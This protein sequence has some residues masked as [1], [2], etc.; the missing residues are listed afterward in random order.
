[1]GN[2][3]KKGRVNPNKAGMYFSLAVCIIALAIGSFSAVSRKSELY[4]SQATTT[5]SVVE[6]R[7]NQ[8]DVKK[9]SAS[10]ATTA[11][12]TEKETTPTTEQKTS[13]KSTETLTSIV[14]NH[15]VLPVGGTLKKEFSNEK[16]QYSETYGDWRIHE[17][18]DIAAKKGTEVCSSGKGKVTKVYDDELLGKTV[19]INHGNEIDCYYCGLKS[20]SVSKGDVVEIGE[21]IGVIGDIP[22]EIAD[23]THLHFMVLKDGKEVDPIKEL[24]IEDKQ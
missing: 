7:K 23:E 17:G 5:E 22:S 10:E 4:E 19:V 2:E 16:L 12:N 13:E 3:H 1:M 11:K 14:A 18:I 20:V 6:I 24:E 8:T 15:F 9:S 21:K